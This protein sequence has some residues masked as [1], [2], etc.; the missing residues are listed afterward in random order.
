MFGMAGIVETQHSRREIGEHIILI[1][2]YFR[3]SQIKF[4]YYYKVCILNSNIKM[5]LV[6]IWPK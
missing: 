1:K 3:N 5:K 2:L 4:L 6:S